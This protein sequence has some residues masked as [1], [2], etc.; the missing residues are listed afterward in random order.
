MN[1]YDVVVVGGGPVGGFIA[2]KIASNGYNIALF[3]EHKKIGEPLKCAGLVTPKVFNYLDFPTT[4]IIQN[5]I[6]GAQIYSPS[7]NVLTIGGDKVHAVVINRSKFDEKIVNNAK[8]KDAEIF[9][10]TKI[11]TANKSK[12]N[13]LV[14]LLQNGEYKQIICSLLIGA[15]GSHSTIRRTFNF[16]APREF[17]YGIGADVKNININP[18]F[19]KIFLGTDKAPGFFSWVIPLNANGSAARIGLCVKSSQKNFLKQC[20]ANLIKIK[21]LHDMEITKKIG[22]AIPLGA[23]KKTTMS[24]VMLVGDAAAQVK[25]TSGGGIY[26]G[27][28]SASHCAAVALEALKCNDYR[29][30]VLS[31]YHKLWLKEIGKELFLGMKF[32][33]IFKTLDDGQFN[34]YIKK[35]N[36]KKTI[37]IICKYG[38]IDYPSKLGFPLL[39]NNP[40]LIKFMPSIFKK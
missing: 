39:K 14:E 38:D 30:Q 32:R 5:K 37:D 12:K 20:F 11:T 13:I 36:N 28:L 31:K 6:F 34:Y 24:N 2:K 8:S 10:N 7:G 18:K 1:R 22:G 16:P 3:E 21:D 40:S 4:N 27:L 29:N 19:V 26:P 9:L 23:L 33:S 25:P 17:L 15:D 35:F